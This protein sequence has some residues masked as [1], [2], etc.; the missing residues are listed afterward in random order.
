MMAEKIVY[1]SSHSKCINNS[2][3]IVQNLLKGIDKFE[4]KEFKKVNN[5]L[6][7][8]HHNK[9]DKAMVNILEFKCDCSMHL[10]KGF[11]LHLISLSLF[12]NKELDSEETG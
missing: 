7:L 8:Y 3:K 1:Y 12:L 4:L 2:P 6:F 10:D 9:P 5:D 11:C